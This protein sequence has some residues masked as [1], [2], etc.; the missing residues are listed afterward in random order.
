MKEKERELRMQQREIDTQQKLAENS[1]REVEKREEELDRKKEQFERIVQGIHP[2]SLFRI[3][4][5][6]FQA[7]QNEFLIQQEQSDEVFQ[8]QLSFFLI[9]IRIH[10]GELQAK[11]IASIG[12]LP[13]LL[14]LQVQRLTAKMKS[15]LVSLLLD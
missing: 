13:E 14:L 6:E 11:K 3:H 12:D 10:R 5:L 9:L 8:L 4:P 15:K 7:K 2:D 1:L